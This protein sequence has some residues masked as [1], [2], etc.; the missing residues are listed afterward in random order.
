MYHGFDSRATRNLDI[1]RLKYIG[2]ISES[3][4]LQFQRAQIFRISHSH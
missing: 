1:S 4:L 2:Y 3:F